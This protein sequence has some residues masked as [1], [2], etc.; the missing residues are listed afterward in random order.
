MPGVTVR[1]MKRLAILPLL[2]L[3]AC[4][5]S[6]ETMFLKD[7]GSPIPDAGTGGSPGV[8]AS[9]AYD[10]AVTAAVWAE[11][12]NGPKVTGG[13]KQ[14]DIWF[15][16]A[17]RGFA[18]SGPASAIYKTEDG[19]STWTTLLTHP[20]TYFRSILFVDDNH[21]FAS[22]L[23]PSPE[24]G[25]TDTNILY[26]TKD[27]GATWAPVTSITGPMPTGICNQ[28]KVDAQHLVA[29]GRVGG[30]AFLMTSSDSGATWASKDLSSQFQMLIDARFTSPTEGILVGGS[31]ANP[32]AC[33]IVHTSDGGQTF[34]T[35]FTSKTHDSLCWKISFPSDQVG[36]VSVQDTDTGTPTFA[37]T[38]DGGK[39][40]SEKP[41]PMNTK[42]PY[43]GI[44]MGFI[45]EEIG[46]VSPDDP[47]LP[48]YRT[49]D[50]GET[51]TAD[52]ALKSPIN[53]FRFV[54]PTTSYAIGAAVWKLTV[55]SG[56]N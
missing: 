14:D 17:T 18:V 33:T 51:W 16:S 24:S 9:A 1:V 31:A 2:A 46:W 42:G 48:T 22:N 43:P 5:N 56:G 28:T 52:A 27:G 53:R 8:D 20:G 15:T 40:W 39:T 45:T 21:G 12:A 7:A 49:L 30:P 38:T 19:G 36:Y 6:T 11:L 55:A 3:L 37:K 23:G 29:V 25:I 47:T 10:Q 54:D 32:M 34:D 4:G 41:L 26:E 50:G 35:V 13:A 44:G